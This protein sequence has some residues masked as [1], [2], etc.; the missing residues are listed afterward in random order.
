MTNWIDA[1]NKP[2]IELGETK[3]VWVCVRNRNGDLIAR[4]CYFVNHP[5][6]DFDGDGEL[7][8]WVSLTCDGEPTDFVGFAEL[9]G[10][11]DYSGYYERLVGVEFWAEIDYPLPPVN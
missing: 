3:H 7:P 6:P 4:D 2:E 11:P 10:H 5:L 1:K 9:L 8:D